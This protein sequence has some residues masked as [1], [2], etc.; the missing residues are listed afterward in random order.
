MAVLGI[1]FRVGMR[2]AGRPRVRRRRGS[3]GGEA[4]DDAELETLV[5]FNG[6]PEGLDVGEGA[7]AEGL[8]AQ[9][10]GDQL[11]QPL[12]GPGAPPGCLAGI[13][14]ASPASAPSRA[15]SSS[16]LATS[17]NPAATETDDPARN[18]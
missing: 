14:S 7:A 16:P 4:F 6:V 15:T 18:R 5:A 9:R 13:R 8:P 11:D 1:V 2:S 17:T 3:F 12:D 10:D